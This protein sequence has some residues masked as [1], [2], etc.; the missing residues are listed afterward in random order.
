[1]LNKDDNEL[2]TRVGPSTAAGSFFRQYWHPILLSSELPHA[3][4]DQLRVRVLGESL[5]AFRDS[6]GQP[7]FLGEHCPH[8]RASLFY[9]RNEEGGLRCAYHGWKF[10]IHGR[11]MEMPNE[12]PESR[13][14]D[15]LRHTA[16]P[17]REQGGAIWIYMG[18]ENPPPPL[19]GL[20]WIDVP[21]GHRYQSKRV[22]N[23]NWLQA[24]EGDIDQ[25]HVGFAHR[26]LD[27]GGKE[28]GRAAID[29][30][31]LS[32]T[33]PRMTAEDMPYGVLVG[34]GRVAEDNQRYWR[35]TQ[36]LFPH[37]VMTGPYGQNPTRHARAW[38]P[39]DDHSTLLF[40]VTFH[41]LEPLAQQAI[42]RMRE[43]IGA[44]YVGE[45]NFQPA[46]NA[47]F[48]AW[49]P[50]ASLENDFFLDREVQKTTHYSG[51]G[52]F[53]AQDAALQGSMGAISER[54]EEHLVTGDV[55][56]VRVRRR[57]LQALAAM[58]GGSGSA[59]AVHEPD[60]YRVR[61][62]A[63]LIPADAS[64]IEATEEHRKV[65]PG[66]NQAGV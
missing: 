17:A 50:R 43:G 6:S 31:R 5:I 13:A 33:H 21:A 23:C 65:I 54:S 45:K 35:L 28:G 12:V 27:R 57:L 56:I 2:L 52:E 44:G 26:R 42:A 60:A 37:W 7:G 4:C 62:A 15:R 1:M 47:P 34:A 25:S 3:D 30:I 8:R 20:E 14:K 51:I 39:I 46:T 11:C 10:D 38:V 59:P 58:R 24:L 55:G 61:G 16:Y 64:W 49:I 19:P 18:P 36:Y 40:T 22:Q 53:W 66:V 48:G 29:R 63:V 32:D 41:P 9:G